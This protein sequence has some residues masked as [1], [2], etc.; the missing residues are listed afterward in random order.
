M[1]IG[2]HEASIELEVAE[3]DPALPP[4]YGG[5]DVLLR[6]RVQWGEFRGATEAWVDAD[7]WEPFLRALEQVERRGSGEAVVEAMSP[8]ELRM[9]VFAAD[10]A[11]HL[12]IEGYVGVRTSGRELLLRFSPIPFESAALRRLLAELRP[13]APPA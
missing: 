12:A 5:G 7:S 8:G 11:G 10:R 9:R 13:S 3:V 1:R 6:A 4:H 2:D